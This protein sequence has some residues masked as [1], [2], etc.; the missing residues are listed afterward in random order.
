MNKKVSILICSY[1]SWNYI[2]N[3]IKSVLNQSYINFELLILDNNSKDETVK[4]IESFQDERIKLFKSNINYWPYWGLNYLLDNSSWDYI[5][6]LDHD[7]LWANNKLELQVDFLEKNQEFIWCGTKTVMFYE[8]DSKYF[9][10]YL[11]EKNYYTIHSSLM[12]R[13]WD[14]KYDDSIFYFADWY[15]QKNILCK[16]KKLIY[17]IDESLTFHLIKDNFNNLS[18]SWFKINYKN[19]KRVFDLHWITLYSFLALWYELSRYII[20]RIKIA[21]TFPKFFKWFDRAPYNVVGNWFKDYK[22]S[23]IEKKFSIK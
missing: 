2:F 4:N 20:I 7:D 12:F 13:K 19:F 11:Q 1:N 16:W 10:Y 8:S 17:N 22:W 3:T 15:F 14:Y 21:K 23:E 6:I 9:E 18:Y 5:A